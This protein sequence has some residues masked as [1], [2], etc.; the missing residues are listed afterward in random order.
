[1]L[2]RADGE[3]EMTGPKSKP[4]AGRHAVVTGAS[5]G[6]GKAIA[7]RLASAGAHVILAARSIDKPT[8]GFSGTVH[9]TA[10]TIRGFGGTATPMALDVTDAKSR[11]DF[12]GAVLDATGGVDILVNNAG[13][14]IYRHIDDYDLSE[15][16]RMIGMYYEGPVHLCNLL[17]PAMKAKGAGWILNLGS[18]SVIKLPQEPYEQHLGYFG[19]DALY[20]SLKSAVH[21]LTLGLAAELREHNI[22]VNLVAPVGAVY[23]PGLD[24]LDLGFGPDHPAAEIEE[25]IAE[26]AL[27]LVSRPPKE[28]T[29]TIA[30]SYKFLDEIGRP[31]MSLDGTR[32]LVARGPQLGEA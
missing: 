13:T 6:I 29:G 30:W 23:T 18:S 21:R 19:Y 9:D 32:I 14:A 7:T 25:Q 8:G 11:E 2:D 22:A 5:R 28:L 1:M 3:D 31:T 17:V 4:L 27:A 12:A 10:E 15:I 16:Q 20:S 26:A 24:N